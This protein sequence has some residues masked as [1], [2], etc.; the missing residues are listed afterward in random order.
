[1]DNARERAMELFKQGYNCSQAVFGAF[2]EE[3]GMSFKLHSQKP[4]GVS[5]SE[6]NLL[7]I[8]TRNEFSGVSSGEVKFLF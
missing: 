3:C 5:M 7:F 8:I 1:M 6:A 2:Y 4:P